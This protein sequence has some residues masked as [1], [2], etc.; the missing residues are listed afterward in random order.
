MPAAWP[1]IPRSRTR[2]SGQRQTTPVTHPPVHRHCIAHAIPQHPTPNTQ[3][4]PDTTGKGA[5]LVL[6][7]L[8]PARSQI[9][10]SALEINLLLLPHAAI[11]CSASTSSKI[12]S[13]F[14]T[15]I[16]LSAST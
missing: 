14:P 8:K 5:V 11:A 16:A 7:N 12:F 2:R 15:A 4:T 3:G 10:A 1:L 9:P 13:V 6:Q